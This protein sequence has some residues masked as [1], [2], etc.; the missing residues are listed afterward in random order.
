MAATLWLVPGFQ[1]SVIVLT[2]LWFQF[3]DGVSTKT[4][5]SFENRG[6]KVRRN[7]ILVQRELT[8][9]FLYQANFL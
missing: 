3:K 2:T 1:T 6:I 5:K 9:S 8:V 4:E 7:G